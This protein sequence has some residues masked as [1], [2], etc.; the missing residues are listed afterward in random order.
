[1]PAKSNYN[2]IYRNLLKSFNP[3]KAVDD[4]DE[5]QFDTGDS[6]YLRLMPHSQERILRAQGST[7]N[8]S[9]VFHSNFNYDELF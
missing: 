2:T 8:T 5:K 6:D 4:T 7:Y 9:I 1:M 3:S